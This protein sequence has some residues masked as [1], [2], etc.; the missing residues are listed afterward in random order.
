MKAWLLSLA[1]RERLIVAGGAA[2][3]LLLVLWLGLWEPLDQRVEE[4]EQS[5]AVQEEEFTWMQQAA[6]EIQQLRRSG[7][8][9]AAGLQGRSLLA[10]VDQATRA[11]GLNSGLKRIEPEGQSRVRVQ[12]EQIGFD[13][14][15]RWL[16]G[17]HRQYGVFTQ[18]ITIEREE[19]PGRVNIRL[20]LDAPA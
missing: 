10:V 14:F 11:A 17:L 3:L 18:S 2:V 12:F 7:G 6:A 4:L 15:M 5:V 16:D 1:P 20:T 13:D 8:Q 9:A 19:A